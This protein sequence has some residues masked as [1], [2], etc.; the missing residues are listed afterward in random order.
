MHVLIGAVDGLEIIIREPS[1]QD[2]TNPYCYYK[3]K[4]VI[5]QNMEGMCDNRMRFKFVSLT[6]PGSTEDHVG[7]QLRE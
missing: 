5:A 4:V 6:S 3:S 2:V 7:L 1:V